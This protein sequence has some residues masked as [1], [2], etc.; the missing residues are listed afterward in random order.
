MVG[1]FDPTEETIGD[2]TIVDG[3]ALLVAPQARSR[4]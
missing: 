1:S 4:P 3:E 2:S